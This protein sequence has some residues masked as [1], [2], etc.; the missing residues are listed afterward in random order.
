M[1]TTSWAGAIRAKL[2][3]IV[4]AGTRMVY[5][6]AGIRQSLLAWLTSSHACTNSFCP[7]WSR[8]QEGNLCWNLLHHWSPR[9]NLGRYLL[10]I[11][12]YKTFVDFARTARKCILTRQLLKEPHSAWTIT[13]FWIMFENRLLKFGRGYLSRAEIFIKSISL[14]LP[15]V[16]SGFHEKVFKFQFTFKSRERANYQSRLKMTYLVITVEPFA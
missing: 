15:F 5:S 2:I 10:P 11:E 4:S 8:F 14:T 9:V 6:R 16:A 3:S 13:T 7:N 1:K 12:H